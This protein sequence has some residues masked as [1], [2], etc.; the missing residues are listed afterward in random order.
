MLALDAFFEPRIF[1][2]STAVYA[3]WIDHNTRAFDATAELQYL[4]HN[5]LLILN[6]GLDIVDGVGALY[7]ESDGL[8]SQS[9]DKDLH[10]TSETEDEL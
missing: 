5:A 9:L 8:S 1:G 3:L 2:N 4:T 7:L 6:L 10:T